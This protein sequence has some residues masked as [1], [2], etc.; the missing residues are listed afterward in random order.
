MPNGETRE[1][2]ATYTP[3]VVDGVVTGFTAHVAD[4]TM[5][6]KR[7]AVLDQTIQEAIMVIEKTKRSFHSKELGALRE[8]LMQI[9]SSW[10]TMFGG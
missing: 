1:S 5:F 2:L 10:L 7:E 6:R 8:R 4:V 3:I 9:R